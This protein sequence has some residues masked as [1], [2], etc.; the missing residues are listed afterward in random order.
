MVLTSVVQKPGLVAIIILENITSVKE[1]Y[2]IYSNAPQLLNIE[3][4]ESDREGILNGVRSFPRSSQRRYQ[5][6]YV[7]PA[8]KLLCFTED[9]HSG[10]K[11]DFSEHNRS[12]A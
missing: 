7:L 6:L 8:D 3:V 12:E 1:K 5:K 9:S 10:R 11:V 4:L 2:S